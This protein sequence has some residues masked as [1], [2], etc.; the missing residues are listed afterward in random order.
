MS[1]FLLKGWDKKYCPRFEC[2]ETGNR[3]CYRIKCECSCSHC[4]HYNECV[5]DITDEKL[6]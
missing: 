5:K 3:S 6:I 1:Y 4:L 2:I